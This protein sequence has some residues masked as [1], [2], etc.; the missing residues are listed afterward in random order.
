MT[1]ENV[2]G[3]WKIEQWLVNEGEKEVLV[4]RKQGMEERWSG[5]QCK[6]G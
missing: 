6:S 3:G 5:R 1:V 4:E 2:R